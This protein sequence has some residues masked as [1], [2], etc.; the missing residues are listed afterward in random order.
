MALDIVSEKFNEWT[1][2]LDNLQSRIAV[3]NN[4]R[5]IPYALVPE[6]LDTHEWA[7]SI[8][9]NEKGSCSPKHVLLGYM[10]TRLG[11]QVKYGVYPFSWDNPLIKY[12]DDLRKLSKII[13][14]GYHCALRVY[15]NGRWVLA[16]ATWDPFLERLG[17][18]VNKGWDGVNDT[19]NAVKALDEILFDTAQERM[20]YARMKKSTF[21]EKEKLSYAE[22][23]NKFNE[24]LI[25]ERADGK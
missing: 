18:P 2:G 12:L 7:C 6:I 13:P 8:L 14:L 22:F 9:K 21:N 23:I 15:I 16:D 5:D 24:W 17:F 10:F 1:K 11:I 3:F 19:L 25:K 20:E 4:I